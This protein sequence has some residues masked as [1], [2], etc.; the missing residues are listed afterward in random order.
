MLWMTR[1]SSETND[2]AMR[3][4]PVPMER[5]SGRTWEGD[6]TLY[7]GRRTV[8]FCDCLEYGSSM[9]SSVEHA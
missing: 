1:A 6:N 3:D 4:G 9:S 2:Q 7:T 5:A 8:I